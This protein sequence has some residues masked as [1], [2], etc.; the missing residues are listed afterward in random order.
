MLV[1]S[2]AHS[3]GR[4]QRALERRTSSKPTPQPA[5]SG[6]SD[7][8]GACDRRRS[9]QRRDR[10]PVVPEIA[11]VVV[12]RARGRHLPRRPRK[13]SRPAQPTRGGF[14]TPP[15]G[16][17]RRGWTTSGRIHSEGSNREPGPTRGGSRL[18]SGLLVERRSLSREEWERWHE[19]LRYSSG[20]ARG[21]VA[22]IVWESGDGEVMGVN[23]W[24]NPRRSRPPILRSRSRGSGCRGRSVATGAAAHGSA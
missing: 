2:R 5:S 20:S 9:G 19:R 3:Y 6:T 22:A 23:V 13:E 17:D 11:G 4:F 18:A 8:I 21:A 10:R 1:T 12:S 15:Y 24:D 16:R 14:S 7:P